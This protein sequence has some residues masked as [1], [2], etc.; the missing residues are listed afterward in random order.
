MHV[1]IIRYLGKKNN[2]DPY[3]I[4]YVNCHPIDV[5]VINYAC[6]MCPVKQKSIYKLSGELC[7]CQVL[8]HVRTSAEIYLQF[9]FSTI[10]L[11][12]RT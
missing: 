8:Y 4:L 5:V 2:D 9:N 7:L 12:H 6:I 11:L 1:P 10:I 3:I